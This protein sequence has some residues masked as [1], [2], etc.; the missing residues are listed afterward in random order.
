MWLLVGR[1]E[2]EDNMSVRLEL[3]GMTLLAHLQAASAFALGWFGPVESALP[4]SS[5][6]TALIVVAQYLL[7]V[8]R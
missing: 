6:V 2:E 3:T 5:I 7:L 4:V 8:L 1:R